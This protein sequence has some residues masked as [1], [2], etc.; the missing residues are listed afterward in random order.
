MEP[1][2][3][4]G[5]AEEFGVLASYRPRAFAIELQAHSFRKPVPG[6]GLPTFDEETF[7]TFMHE[8]AHLVQDRSTFRGV[9]DFLDLWDQVDAV[10][11]YVRAASA[12]VIIPIG[13]MS[14]T[15][16]RLPDEMKWA[17]GLDQLRTHREPRRE[18]TRDRYW[19]FVDYSVD[20]R[21]L[22]LAKRDIRYPFVS[23]QMVDNVTGA[24]YRHPLG[25][26]E[27]KEAYAVA[28]G[29][30]HG[31]AEKQPSD[32]FEYLV[33]ERIL[34]HHFGQLVP[35]QTIALCHWAL[36]DLAPATALFAL[37][38]LFDEGALPPSDRLYDIARQE[39]L[40]RQFEE[41]CRDVIQM[42]R[43][44]E[45]SFHARESNLENMFRWYATHAERLL[46]LHY[47]LERRFPLDTMLC[48]RSVG[49]SP[50]ARGTELSRLFSEVEVPLII[51]PEGE[52]YSINHTE[53]TVNAVFLNRCVGDLFTRLWQGRDEGWP[54][55]LHRG[56]TLPMRDDSVCC[57]RPWK[58]S[59]IRPTC[60]YGAAAQ[61]IGLSDGK[62]PKCI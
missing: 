33:V 50:E 57:S 26:W 38:E 7:P 49:S 45:K 34:T 2:P 24:Q 30:L 6:P 47:N 1:G 46:G 53:D 14:F 61:I 4:D 60:P 35:E 28:V 20:W 48:K 15:S 52:F 21:T 37:I 62:E 23:V 51:W 39:A 59:A 22:H 56:C 3:V 31:G 11:T 43:T 42:L 32:S 16:C 40:S 58:K 8:M 19:A 44:I 55:P 10:S 25:A 27:I 54:C 18:W 5:N 29:L 9:M 41:N 12:A 17:F 36:Q 13:G